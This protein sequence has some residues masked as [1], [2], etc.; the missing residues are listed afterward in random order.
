M[1]ALAEGTEASVGA[2][3]DD[4]EAG[5]ARVGV[6]VIAETGVGVGDAGV[7][8]DVIVEASV[9]VGDAGVGVDDASAIVEVEVGVGADVADVDDAKAG[10]IVNAVMARVIMIDATA[11]V[12]A[13]AVVVVVVAAAGENL[14]R[15][16]GLE[17][18]WSFG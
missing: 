17:L 18:D 3:F 15:D 4:A 1:A 16:F 7:G 12:V 5:V 13:A 11:D 2:I 9:A 8:V 10:T 14:N 6:G